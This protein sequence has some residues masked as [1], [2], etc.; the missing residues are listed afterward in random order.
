MIFV[1][2]VAS[3]ELPHR[4]APSR[5]RSGSGLSARGY[6][7][8]IPALGRTV[9]NRQPF[10]TSRHPYSRK[11]TDGTRRCS[12]GP[13]VPRARRTSIA[14]SAFDRAFARL[15]TFDSSGVPTPTELTRFL[16]RRLP[17]DGPAPIE[18]SGGDA[19]LGLGRCAR[20]GPA[21]PVLASRAPT[22]ADT[23]P[24]YELS[25]GFGAGPRPGRRPGGAARIRRAKRADTVNPGRRGTRP[26]GW[27]RPDHVLP[28]MPEMEE[29]PIRSWPDQCVSGAC[30]RR[31]EFPRTPRTDAIDIRWRR[32]QA[33]KPAPPVAARK[34]C[35]SA[36]T[37]SSVPTIMPGCAT[38]TGAR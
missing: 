1:V 29:S 11:P 28:G 7:F 13:V 4:I 25:A 34:P 24:G 21:E 2:T 26:Q 23:V 9:T 20:R 30:S 5:S 22:I 17:P 36:C 19:S 18:W 33:S 32:R 10:S 8:P 3:P 31:A 15:R 37:A 6:W 27:N 35:G 16:A 14:C 38:R 12:P